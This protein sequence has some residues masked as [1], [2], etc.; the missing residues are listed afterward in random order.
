MGQRSNEARDELKAA[1]AARRAVLEADAERALLESDR[2]DVTLP[3]RRRHLGSEHPVIKTMHEIVSVFR[4]LGYSVQEGPV[5]ETDYYN[6]EA[7]NFPPNHPARDMQ[8]T[9]WLD[10]GSMSHVLGTDA[11]GRD[12]LSRLIYGARVSLIAVVVA[13]FV[14]LGLVTDGLYA[15]GAGSTASWMRPTSAPSGPT[16]CASRPKARSCG[17]PSTAR[18]PM[19]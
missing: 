1:A 8:D 5:I 14:M 2:I 16:R 19:R 9:F 17:A 10:G 7:L 13:V 11:F 3:G 4:N 6:F 12:V 18:K 15:L